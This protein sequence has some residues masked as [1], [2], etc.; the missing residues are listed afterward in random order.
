MANKKLIIGIAAAAAAL[1]AV[2]LYVSK[3]RSSRRRYEEQV[4]DAKEHFKGKLNEFQRKAQ[5][6]FKNSPEASRDAI[7]GAE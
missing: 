6:Q 5:K 2:G 7:A 3:Q 4:E 1:A